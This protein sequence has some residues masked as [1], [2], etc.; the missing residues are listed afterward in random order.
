[1]KISE[2]VVE[3]YRQDATVGAAEI[4]IVR[5]LIGDGVSGTGFLSHEHPAW[6]ARSRRERAGPATDDGLLVANARSARAS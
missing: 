1:M 3:R 5:V 6:R 2:L 4:L